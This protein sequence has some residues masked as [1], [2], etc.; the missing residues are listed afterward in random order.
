[1]YF[2]TLAIKEKTGLKI[3]VSFKKIAITFLLFTVGYFILIA[4]NISLFSNINQTQKADAAIVL[5]AG[6]WNNE[7][8]P[9]FKERINHSIFLYKKGY[10]KSII[11]TGGTSD[12]KT[13][14]ES[15]VAKMYAIKNG[16]A[17]QDIFIEEKSK[18]TQENL[19]FAKEIILQNNF[20]K[21]L[22]VS[23]PL[24]MKRSMMMAKDLNLEAY[25]SPTTTSKYQ[26]TKAKFIFLLRETFFY[27]AYQ[28]YN[29]FL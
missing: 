20:S 9:V 5:G 14:S 6:I 2:Y 8:S 7:P 4:V 3:S 1:M 26:S 21:I 13:L 10:V 29:F 23:D 27:I 22:L 24:H 16:V 11:F 17:T 15:Y 28:V 18:I 19:A 12:N 25:S